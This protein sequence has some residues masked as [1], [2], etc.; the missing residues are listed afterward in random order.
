MKNGV[1]F[2]LLAVVFSLFSCRE[3]KSKQAEALRLEKEA[4]NF[5]SGASTQPDS[6]FRLAR[7]IV[8][9]S[10]TACLD[11]AR[12]AGRMSMN[13]KG[14][15][16][17]LLLKW[18]A[19]YLSRQEPSER[20]YNALSAVEN[21][22]GGAYYYNGDYDKALPHFFRAIN[23]AYKA[24]NPKQVPLYYS[25][26]SRLY[27]RK[28]DYPRSAYYCHQALFVGDSLKMSDEM[29][30][31]LL[32]SLGAC[33]M[34]M[35]DFPSAKRYFDEA[36][37][38]V[39]HMTE[40][41]LGYLYTYCS[42]FYYE[43]LYF[44]GKGSW[45]QALYYAEKVLKINEKRERRVYYNALNNYAF[46]C[47]KTGKDARK[48]AADLAK[49]E[50]YYV[51]TDNDDMKYA[52]Q[53]NLLLLAIR[54][55]QVARAGRLIA[56]LSDKDVSDSEDE[57]YMALS[58]YYKMRNQAAQAVYYLKKSQNVVDSL[59]NVGMQQYQANLNF[60]YQRDTTLLNHKIINQ[61][62]ES[63]I[64]ELKWKYL[65][66]TMVGILV[67]LCFIGYFLYTK[68]HRTLLQQQYLTNM[69]HLKMQNIRN[70][71]SPHFTFNMLNREILQTPENGAMYKRLMNLAHL[72]R[73]SLDAT[74]Q[75]AIPLS[76][77]LDFTQ[78]YIEMLQECGKTFNFHLEVEDSVNQEQT[79]IPSMLI[80]I[81]VENAVKH[82]FVSEEQSED[83]EISIT[84]TDKK[85]GIQIEIVNNGETY[86]PFGHDGRCEKGI[87]M[88]VIYQSLLLMNMKNKEKI[89]FSI[90]GRQQEGASGTRVSIYIPYRFDFT[91]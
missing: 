45:Q 2:C 47:I 66:V 14:D 1:I 56:D 26:I 23:A 74:R 84:I 62:Q 70:C 78:T 22:Y 11:R 80:Q 90:S 61:R 85:T 25:N 12:M 91:V 57:W 71:I 20:I 19:D 31:F 46:L 43:Q 30:G 18:P 7:Q 9:D 24:N 51:K 64:H 60:K 75:V 77:E 65:T 81:P 33:Y 35:L 67:V 76:Q 34:N 49:C 68:R 86:S 72:L 50:S 54:E 40:D 3:Q 58:D 13:D 82:G 38:F 39:P 27:D 15:S 4:V 59:R 17:L 53:I 48:I 8:N 6:L 5:M 44:T 55:K 41:D 83:R 52:V 73:R 36:L 63:E 16:A 28:S 69:N 10:V 29:R 88:Q 42:I 21:C 37:T 89:T 32:T 79:L 87:G